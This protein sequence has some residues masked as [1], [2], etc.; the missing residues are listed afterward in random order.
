MIITSMCGN[1]WSILRDY[2]KIL[3]IALENDTQLQLKPAG[4]CSPKQHPVALC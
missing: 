4:D 3:Q 1:D 2:W